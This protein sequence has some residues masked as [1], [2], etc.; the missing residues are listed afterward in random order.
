MASGFLFPFRFFN[1]SAYILC[2]ERFIRRIW[3]R[4]GGGQQTIHRL[5]WLGGWWWWRGGGG[6][7][8]CWQAGR[9]HDLAVCLRLLPLAF[10]DLCPPAWS[11]F[12]QCLIGS[13]TTVPSLSQ[14]FHNMQIILQ[15][16]AVWFLLWFSFFFCIRLVSALKLYSVKKEVWWT[17]DHH[18]CFMLKSWFGKKEDLGR[19]I[20][21]RSAVEQRSS[22]HL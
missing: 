14:G 9:R 19:V 8:M 13:V 2:L 7:L 5:L 17:D 1:V 20:L 21:L 3:W 11:D 12:S 22:T 4:W 6:G 15:S 18:Q 10:L 16:L